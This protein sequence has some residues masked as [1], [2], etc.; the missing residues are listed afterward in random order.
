MD[1]W[2]LFTQKIRIKNSFS[3][4]DTLKFK[5]LSQKIHRYTVKFLI[6]GVIVLNI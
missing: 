2:Y 1:T 6:P 4:M 5:H 3:E